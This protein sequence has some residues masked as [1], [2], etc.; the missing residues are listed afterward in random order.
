METTTLAS[1]MAT[2]RGGL[3]SQCPQAPEVR[4]ARRGGISQEAR[5]SVDADDELG[6]CSRAARLLLRELARRTER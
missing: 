1:G 6:T 5:D 3:R 4:V 2:V